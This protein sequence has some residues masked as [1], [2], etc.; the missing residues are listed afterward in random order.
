MTDAL[1]L[2]SL[3]TQL[4][5]DLSTQNV[6]QLMELCLIHDAEPEADPDF[7]RRLKQ[8]I[9]RR[10]DQ[11]TIKNQATQYALLKRFANRFKQPLS[12]S[13]ALLVALQQHIDPA[14]YLQQN[15]AAIIDALND[16]AVV[17]WLCAEPQSALLNALLK[18]DLS[19]G[20]ALSSALLRDALLA[21]EHTVTALK[22]RPHF[23]KVLGK[24]RQALEVFLLS[25]AW[26][27][28]FVQENLFAELGQSADV[29]TL[30]ANQQEL[31]GKFLE[32]LNL[33]HLREAQIP[34]L[35]TFIQDKSFATK[36]TQKQYFK[37][38]LTYVNGQD[39]LWKAMEQ[40]AM[41]EVLFENPA[42]QQWFWRDSSS[43]WERFFNHPPSAEAFFGSLII[44]N[45]IAAAENWRNRISSYSQSRT[46][47]QQNRQLIHQTIT[48]HYLLL[49]KQMINSSTSGSSFGSSGQ[50]GY[51]FVTIG[52]RIAS[53][54]RKDDVT[55]RYADNNVAAQVPERAVVQPTALTQIDAVVFTPANYIIPYQQN[56]GQLAYEEWVVN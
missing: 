5:V 24:N 53:N 19:L 33:K 51:L 23:A 15:Q 36:L 10:F 54:K 45:T 39:F 52:I 16:G 21:S 35:L 13:Q 3:R 26:Q 40:R 29:I 20:W 27:D 49:D 14:L 4:S 34:S 48:P 17:S 11:D 41:V 32:D 31:G 56:N 28:Y 55:V 2:G 8:E 1:I 30:L 18:E 9:A 38:L 6:Q 7:V 25:K 37:D 44:L 43:R 47:M 46:A 42:L 12:E 22:A 50:A